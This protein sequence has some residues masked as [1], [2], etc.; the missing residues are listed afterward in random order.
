[1]SYNQQELDKKTP[2][3]STLWS[4]PIDQKFNKPLLPVEANIFIHW[5]HSKAQG[6]AQRQAECSSLPDFGLP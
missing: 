3:P 5:W 1:V 4:Y 6:L 2:S